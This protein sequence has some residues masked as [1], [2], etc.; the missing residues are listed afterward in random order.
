MNQLLAK[1]RRLLSPGAPASQV[2]PPERYPLAES[3]R[4]EL[5]QTIERL[6]TAGMLTPGEVSQE[7]LVDCAE[8]ED[9]FE[10]MDIVMVANILHLVQE[11]RTVPLE[12]LAFF[13]DQVETTDDDALAVVRELAR[14]SGQSDSVRGLR[15]RMTGE[16][17]RRGNFPPPNAVVEFEL[18]TQA[19][20]VP[21]TMYGKNAPIG[22]TEEV[23]RIFTRAGDARRFF[24]AGFDTFSI[25][26]YAVPE[27]VAALNAALGPEP[28]WSEVPP[29]GA[30]PE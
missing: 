14:L 30:N 8:R 21:F 29:P 28:T 13:V 20:A 24:E 19:H 9:D 6:E 18:G 4:V 1:L 12:R 22:L 16:L 7:A 5:F 27:K 10:E 11:E 15:F 3:L 25:V 23:A 2:N 17:A 26:A